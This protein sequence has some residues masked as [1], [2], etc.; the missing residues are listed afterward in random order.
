MQLNFNAEE[1][2]GAYILPEGERTG[3]IEQSE[4]RDTKAGDCRYLDLTW[5]ILEGDHR[6]RLV[7][8]RVTL[9]NPSEKAVQFGKRRLSSIC[10]AVGKEQIQDSAELHDIPCR[11][12][13]AKRPGL[14]GHEDTNEVTRVRKLQDGLPF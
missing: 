5:K 1:Y 7:W 6:D 10:F 11:I 9:E 8:Q 13:V 4:I 2:K 14:E 12:F 3:L